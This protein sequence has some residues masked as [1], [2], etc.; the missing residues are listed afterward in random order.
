MK[1][2]CG[3]GVKK[4]NDS[5]DF[6]RGV[7]VENLNHSESKFKNARSRDPELESKFSHQ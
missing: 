5:G 6:G 1:K 4:S 3:V 7:G 2:D